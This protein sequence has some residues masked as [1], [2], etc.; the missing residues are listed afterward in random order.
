MASESDIEERTSRRV[1]ILSLL[2]RRLKKPLVAVVEPVQPGFVA[3]ATGISVFGYGDDDDEAVEVLLQGIEGMC[4][5]E[6]ILDLRATI[7][8]KLLLENLT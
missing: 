1:E 6:G 2:G 5:D 3:H 4:R 7:Q 8:R